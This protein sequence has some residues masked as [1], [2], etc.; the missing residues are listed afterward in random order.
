M[1]VKIVRSMNGAEVIATG[2]TDMTDMTGIT[3]AGTA[4]IETHMTGITGAGTAMTGMPAMTDITG[5]GMG[6]TGMGE[7]GLTGT[8]MTETM[9]K[10]QQENSHHDGEI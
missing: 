8:G 5:T 1:E 10:C 2:M 6:E 4:M 7:T 9:E 3:G